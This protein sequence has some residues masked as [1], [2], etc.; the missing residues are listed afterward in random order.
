MQPKKKNERKKERK[1]R[2][3]KN[4]KKNIEWMNVEEEEHLKPVEEEVLYTT[5]SQGLSSFVQS[6]TTYVTLKQL[7]PDINFVS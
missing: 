3:K 5:I 6:T 2:K 7:N 1:E 4:I